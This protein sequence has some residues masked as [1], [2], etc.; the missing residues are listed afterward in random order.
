MEHPERWND[1]VILEV[2]QELGET[3]GRVIAIETSMRETCK[4]VKEILKSTAFIPDMQRMIVQHDKRIG[5]LEQKSV[6]HDMAATKLEEHLREDE[7]PDRY[8]DRNIAAWVK[9]GL[10]AAAAGGIAWIVAKVTGE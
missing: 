9:S 6:L 5:E 1:G 3:K 4:D 10:W 2:K 8:V 7:S